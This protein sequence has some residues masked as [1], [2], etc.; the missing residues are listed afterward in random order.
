MST[1]VH[2]NQVS[3]QFSMPGLPSFSRAPR[4][5]GR[6]NSGP[7]IETH[8]QAILALDRVSFTIQQA[9]IFGLVGSGGSGKSTMIRMLAGLLKPDRGEISIFGY[10]VVRHLLQVQ[11]LTNRVSVDASFFKQ[12]SAIENLTYGARL[13]GLDTL[14]TRRWAA[15]LLERLGLGEQARA[16]PLE[17]L[18]RSAQQIVVIARAMLTRPSLL[19]L[20]EPLA[21]LDADGRNSVLH[22]LQG[23]RE[24]EGTTIVIATRNWF[25]ALEICDCMAVLSE[26]RVVSLEN[27]VQVREAH[28]ALA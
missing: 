16:K 12:L 8:P 1:A 28:L 18:S 27:S 14:E 25:D 22:F 4:R 23:L 13:H 5:I 3:K 6:S 19:L 24:S 26:G 15:E 10:D 2:V 9:E 7:L 20:D 17:S 21:G 11:H